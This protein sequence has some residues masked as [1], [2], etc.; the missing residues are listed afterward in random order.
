MCVRR[1]PRLWSRRDLRG[2]FGLDLGG[3]DAAGEEAEQK[4]G[5]RD[6][7]R[8]G[9][10]ADEGGDFGGRQ[11]RLAV[12][13]NQMAADAERGNCA[14]QVDGLVGGAGRGHQRSAGEDSGAM[15]LDD[16][17]VDSRRQSKIVRV[18]N[19]T[20][21]RL[22]LSRVAALGAEYNLADMIRGDR[23]GFAVDRGRLAQLVRAP[24]LQAGSRGFESLTAHQDLKANERTPDETNEQGRESGVSE[25][26]YIFLR[27]GAMPEAS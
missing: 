1:R 25:V 11:G 26:P 16:G 3:A 5:E 6:R 2:G 9:A 22:S 15:Q 18:D 7:E 17:A 20:A 27:L 12:D 13:Q 14:G 19:E 21:H 24:A 4:R 8:A 23:N 10:S